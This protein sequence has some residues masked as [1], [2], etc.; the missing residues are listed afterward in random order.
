MGSVRYTE[1]RIL[2]FPALPQRTL[3]TLTGSIIHVSADRLTDDR[4]GQ[5][6]FK[7]RLRPDPESLELIVERRLVAG[8][9][10]EVSIA[11]GQRTAGRYLLDPLLDAM[12]RSM[13]ER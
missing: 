2:P 13:R 4:T 12:N 8:M 5:S 7:V 11:T 3:P 6:F 10:A 9:P 1:F